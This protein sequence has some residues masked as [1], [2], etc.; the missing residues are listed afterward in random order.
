MPRTTE[1]RRRP[2]DLGGGGEVEMT[3]PWRS[4]VM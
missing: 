2:I 1:L 4:G 3:Q